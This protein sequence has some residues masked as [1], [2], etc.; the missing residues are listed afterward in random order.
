[1]SEQQSLAAL[2]SSARQSQGSLSFT[3]KSLR[4]YA[5]QRKK[6]ANQFQSLLTDIRDIKTPIEKQAGKVFKNL[7]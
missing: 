6:F 4:E 3:S 1:M 2:Q 5:D 7:A